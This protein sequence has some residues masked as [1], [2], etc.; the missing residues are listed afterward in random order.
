MP[1]GN[2]QALAHEFRKYLGE[3][4]A[5]CEDVRRSRN[6]LPRVQVQLVQLP[7]LPSA[8]LCGS[9]R[10][11]PTLFPEHLGH[12][13]DRAPGAYH[14]GPGLIQ[15]NSDPLR[16]DH[17]P[18]VPDLIGGDELVGN[19]QRVP[20]RHRI[21]EIRDHP[22]PNDQVPRIKEQLGQELATPFL[23]P[24]GP[25]FH[26]LVGPPVPKKSSRLA[27][28]RGPDAACLPARCRSRVG[29]AVFVDDGYVR[30]EPGEIKRR[31]HPE[32]PRTDDDDVRG[33]LFGFV[34][35]VIQGLGRVDLT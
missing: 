8:H 1:H 17:R 19:A 28:V 13:L 33:S 12:A 29:R 22:G 26:G 3:P 5:A 10:H 21:L 9:D 35:S 14:T 6:L 7:S 2:P 4:R 32:I 34:R 15:P 27:T 20:V 30:S 24:Q 23:I 18:A 25:A 11:L 16:A 31:P